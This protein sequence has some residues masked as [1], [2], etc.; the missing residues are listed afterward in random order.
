MESELLIVGG[1]PAGLA[2]A[3]EA[4]QAGAQVTLLDENAAPGG[5]IYRHRIWRCHAKTHDPTVEVE[6]LAPEQPA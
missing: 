3:I 2:A 1:G 4:V 6:L 5:Q